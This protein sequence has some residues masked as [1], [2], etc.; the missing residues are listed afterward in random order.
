MKITTPFDLVLPPQ[1]TAALKPFCA[2]QGASPA[3]YS[4]MADAF[5]GIVWCKR[6]GDGELG[7]GHLCVGQHPDGSVYSQSSVSLSSDLM[8]RMGAWASAMRAHAALS[9]EVSVPNE[10]VAPGRAL[11]AALAGE[12][13]GNARI[14]HFPY[15]GRPFSIWRWCDIVDA[16]GLSMKSPREEYDRARS[17]VIHLS[18][19]MPGAAIDTDGRSSRHVL[20]LLMPRLHEDAMAT[21]VLMDHGNASIEVAARRS[22]LSLGDRGLAWQHSSSCMK[23]VPAAR[24]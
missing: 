20:A 13:G 16:N 1:V 12:I 9:S 21:Q 8:L 5:G 11:A 6:L 24:S 22:V 23:K 2:E 7:L 18:S 10:L 15:V 14:R 4:L 19:L 17:L 3:V